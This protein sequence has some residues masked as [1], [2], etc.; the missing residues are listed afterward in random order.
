MSAPARPS[1]LVVPHDADARVVDRGEH[2]AGAVGRAVVDDD[3]LEVARASGR[4]RSSPPR[5]SWPRGVAG[6]ED[7]GHERRAHRPRREGSLRRCPEP[8]DRRFDLVV[9]TVDRTDELSPRCSTRSTTQTHPAFR[10]PRRR[11][12]P[13]RPRRTTWLAA[14][15]DPRPSCGS[16]R[17][18]GLSRARNAAL[19]T[20]RRPTSSRSRTTTASTRRTSSTR[21][22]RGSPTTRR[23]A[24]SAARSRPPTGASIGRWPAHPAPHRR[25]HRLA[26]GELAHDLPPARASSSGSAR[27]TRRSASARDAAW[28]SGEEIDYLVRALRAGPRRVRP[29]ARRAPP[30]QAGTRPTSS[31]RSAAATAASVGYVL[32]RHGYPARAVARMLVRPAVGALVSL[33]LLDTARGRAS[34]PRRSW[35][36]VLRPALG[37]SQR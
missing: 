7:D 25:R 29:V 13:R 36:R 30:R 15:S 19:R 32:A 1:G 31:S 26:R 33:V 9:A 22:A 28:S 4:A 6:R 3:E 37:R 5:R 27:S 16:A 34:T 35:G 12:E 10:A 17:R 23:S 24:A 18:R 11:P 21:V 2:V 20:A 8:S 14:H